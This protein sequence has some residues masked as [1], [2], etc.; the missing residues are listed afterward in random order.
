MTFFLR[1]DKIILKEGLSMTFFDELSR[2]LSDKGKEA[3]QKAKETA[4]VLQLKAQIASEKSKLKE[5]YGAVGV[6][7]YKKHRD[8]EDN[9]FQDLFREIGNVRVNVAAMEERVQGMDGSL[10]CPN[11]KNVMKK[12]S[13]F[14]SRC[15]TALVTEEP[16]K[17]DVVAEETAIVESDEEEVAEA[18]PKGEPEEDMFVDDVVIE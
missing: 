6:L 1:Q 13:A 11:C 5:L 17:D 15:G 2:A 10:V 18:P 8:E 14:C 16:A 7:Y 12:G 4:G 9:E 3:A